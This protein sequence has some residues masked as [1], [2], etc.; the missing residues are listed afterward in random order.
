MIWQ[1]VQINHKLFHLF[2]RISYFHNPTRQEQIYTLVLLNSTL[3][4]VFN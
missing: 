2:I 3:A 4:G 1:D